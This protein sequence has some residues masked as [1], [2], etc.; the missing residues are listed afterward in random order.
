[1]AIL[2]AIH[3]GGLR[4]EFRKDGHEVDYSKV[5]VDAAFQ[6]IEDLFESQFK[7]QIS[8]A[9]TAATN[10]GAIGSDSHSFSAAEKD[11]LG[12]NYT[13]QKGNGELV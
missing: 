1:M 3:R 13:L 5:A 11:R 10:A 2:N 6:A 9:I 7:P 8:A 12:A 4:E